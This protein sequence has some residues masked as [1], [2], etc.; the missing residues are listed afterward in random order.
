MASIK[1]QPTIEITLT[2]KINEEE[3]RALD[4]LSGYNLDDFL[5]F[6]YQQMG[7]SYMQPHEAGFREFLRS[8]REIVPLWLARADN[9]R[10]LFEGKK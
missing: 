4:A 2:L 6:F 3:A 9:A 10:R 1:G 8:V 5:K 7:T